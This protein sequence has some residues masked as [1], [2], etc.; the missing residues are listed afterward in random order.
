MMDEGKDEEMRKGIEHGRPHL[1][2]LK[3][4]FCVTT[5][6]IDDDISNVP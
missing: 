2:Y 1:C 5:C 6:H 3:A 4:H